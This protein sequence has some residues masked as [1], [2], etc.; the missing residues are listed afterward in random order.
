M[1]I[2]IVNG[3]LVDPAHGIDDTLDVHIDGAQVGLWGISQARSY[4]GGRA[5]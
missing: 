2:S 3:R 5:A 4:C 1:S